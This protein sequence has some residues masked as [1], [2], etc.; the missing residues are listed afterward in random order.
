MLIEKIFPPKKL[1][2]DGGLKE[3][4]EKADNQ[5]GVVDSS[6]PNSF[7]PNAPYDW[8]LFDSYFN[9]SPA[10]PVDTSNSTSLTSDRSFSSSPGSLVEPFSEP[11]ISEWVASL[12]STELIEY[13]ILSEELRLMTPTGREIALRK[14]F[15]NM[16]L[17]D[18]T[19]KTYIGYVLG[20]FFS[21]LK[22]HPT[23]ETW[24]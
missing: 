23:A 6:S 16:Q 7:S 14:G 20:Y 10:K 1:E 15:S 22:S 19:L 8:V 5:N 11:I 2:D 17:D 4:L 21:Y 13:N 3:L 24:V 18:D 12:N 9:P